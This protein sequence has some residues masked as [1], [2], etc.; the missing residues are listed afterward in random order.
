MGK[1]NIKSI[2]RAECGQLL[3]EFLVLVPGQCHR[4]VET[5]KQGGSSL[6]EELSGGSVLMWLLSGINNGR[7]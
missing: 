1:S 2:F 7:R 5:V 6:A 3:G 4:E